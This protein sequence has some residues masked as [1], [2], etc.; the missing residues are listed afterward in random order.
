MRHAIK[1]FWKNEPIAGTIRLWTCIPD[2]ER[3]RPLFD[4]MFRSMLLGAR[5]GLYGGLVM[6][7]AIAFM[8]W[9]QHRHPAFLLWF[10]TL[11]GAVW[12]RF[13]LL[14]FWDAGKKTLGRK[15]AYTITAVYFAVGMIWGLAGWVFNENAM[16]WAKFA[17]LTCQYLLLVMSV[18]ALSGYLPTYI[19]FATPLCLLIPYPWMTPT[20]SVGVIIGIGTLA[21]FVICLV[22]AMRHARTQAESIKIR[23][24]L[25]EKHERLH[26]LEK[27]QM[28]SEER[29]RLM[30]DMHDGL[31][32]SLVSAL[33]VAERGL[34]DNAEVAQ[35]LKSCLED[36]KL[37]IDSMEPV[38]ADLLLLLATL[39]FRIGSRLERAGI[40]LHWEVETVP[41]LDWLNPKNALNILRIL[42]EAFTNIIKHTHATEIRVATQ[43]RG[44][45]IVV[46]ITDNGQGFS[47]EQA[48]AVGGK[49]LSNQ[50]RRA[51]SIQAEI[52]WESGN[53]GTR[54]A[55]LLPINRL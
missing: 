28:L 40:V 14:R 50:L 37:A 12:Q 15:H 17:L 23:F 19:A 38:D 55:L 1:A 52:H 8:F 22:L 41:A 45:R 25:N 2:P 26:Q 49:G 34:M 20:S 27:K 33:R 24:E 29:Q 7:A 51:E 54:F 47:V 39:R 53:I 16:I 11:T 31:G 46:A 13:A 30:Q 9:N 43:A 3:E 18:I 32:S 4:V 5:S 48:L 44:D 10:F 42:Q 36:L 6:A 21:T 35:I